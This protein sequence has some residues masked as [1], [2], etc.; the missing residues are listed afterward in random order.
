MTGTSFGPS[1]CDNAVVSNDPTVFRMFVFD[2]RSCRGDGGSGGF[3]MD[4]GCAAEVVMVVSPCKGP[5]KPLCKGAG[6]L[7]D[8]VVGFVFRSG[9][10]A[11][12]VGRSADDVIECALRS[13][14]ADTH[15]LM[16]DG[17]TKPIG[18]I[19][20]GELV[21]AHEPETGV[22]GARA[23][24]AVWPHEDWLLEFTVEGGSVTT[25]E[26]HHFWNVTDNQWQETQHIDPG[27]YLLTAEGRL[28]EA[29]N[30]DWSTSHYADAYDLTIEGLHTYFIVAGDEQVLVHNCDVATRASELRSR[31][32]SN[33]VEINTPNGR[34]SIDLEGKAHFEKSLETVIDTPHV[35]FETRHV[36]PNGHESYTSGPVR[37]ATHDDLRLVEQVLRERGF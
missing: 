28:V 29:G 6:R 36:G 15:V 8:D 34:I 11:G 24:L 1:S 14:S 16:A 32:G 27:D 26:D 33:R 22:S 2:D 35:K 4:L 19:V 12:V 31:S 23:V 30:L 3:D 25:T 21:W 20:L 17:S 7:G 10:E 18:A 9:D 5:L 13:F 37:A